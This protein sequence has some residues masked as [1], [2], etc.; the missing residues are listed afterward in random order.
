MPFLFY[1]DW[2]KTLN[3]GSVKA[4]DKSTIGKAAVLRQYSCFSDRRFSAFSRSRNSKFLA[5]RGILSLFAIFFFSTGNSAELSAKIDEVMQ[6]KKY[7]HADW[8]VLI[9]DVATQDTLWDLNSDRMFMPASTT[10]LFSTAALLQAYGEDYHFKTPLYAL[11]NIKKGVLNGNLILVGQGDLTFGGRQAV[12]SDTI[13]FTEYDHTYANTI[14]EV[15]LTPEDPLNAINTLAK[16]VKEKG[17]IR[18]DGDVLI[19]DRLFETI[20]MRGMMISPLMINENL[21]DIVIHP[22]QIGK[23]AE[24]SSRPQVAGYKVVNDCKT[25]AKSEPLQISV[26]SDKT[27]QIIRVSGTIPEDQKEAIRTFSIK[28]PKKF[29]RDAL[30]QALR[31]QGI[32]LN[33]KSAQL[34]AKKAYAKLQPIAEWISP[35]LS[36]YTKLIL[37]VSHNLGADLIPLLL[38][39]KNG[40]TTYVSGMHGLGKFMADEVQVSPDSYVFADASGGD[41]NRLTPQAEVKLLEYVRSWPKERFQRFYNG[42]SILGVD[43][44][45]QNVGKGT[46]LVGKMYAKGGTGI[47][48]SLA[49]DQYF[50]STLVL[51]GYIEKMS[52][53]LLEIV[54]GVNNANMPKINDIFPIYEDL[55]QISEEFY[56]ISGH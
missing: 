12:G 30:M 53:G 11:G 5:N 18:I 27:G 36:E 16:K 24:I 32:I 43:G 47:S 29:A 50:L 41:G 35:P 9:K 55:S 21:I 22:T 15:F 56:N 10:K 17:I 7:Q 26:D 33:M 2:S 51:A 8:F 25:V 4:A 45:L 14:P 52:E 1:C 49:T 31:E 40:N 37:K 6:K 28:D 46:S 20:E 54:V 39:A 42:L 23:S 19:D 13:S 34:P 48:Y 38:A 44:N 3:L